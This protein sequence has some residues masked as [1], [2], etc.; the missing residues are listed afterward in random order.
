MCFLFS[1]RYLTETLSPTLNP[2]ISTSDVND[3]FLQSAPL[4]VIV[5]AVGLIAWI[6]PEQGSAGT[7]GGATCLVDCA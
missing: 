4:T 3:L 5:F 1:N 7:F 6:V 2:D